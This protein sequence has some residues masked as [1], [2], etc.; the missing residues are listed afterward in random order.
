MAAL[1]GE[2]FGDVYDSLSR[3][4]FAGLARG[5]IGLYPLI[6]S[7]GTYR[8]PLRT[9]LVTSDSM[10]PFTRNKAIAVYY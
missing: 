4:L 3:A 1:F 9:R 6:E 2:W 8:M 5:A 7:I 10:T